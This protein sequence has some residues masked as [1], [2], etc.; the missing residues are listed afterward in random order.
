MKR[1]KTEGIVLHRTEK[2]TG[3]DYHI[4]VQRDGTWDFHVPL[5]DVGFHACRYNQSSIAVAIFGDFAAL[6]PGLNWHPTKEQIDETIHLVQYIPKHYPDIKWIAGHTQLGAKGTAIP[7]K[8]VPGHTCPGENFPLKR[9]I[10]A[11]GLLPLNEY[12]KRPTLSV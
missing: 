2:W 6:E 11:S 7:N 5:E 8:L 9:I 10:A 3:D 4:I 12:L 1:P